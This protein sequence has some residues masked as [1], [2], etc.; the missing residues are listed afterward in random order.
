[1]LVNLCEFIKVDWTLWCMH[2]H[3]P[4]DFL[5][6]GIKRILLQEIVHIKI[7]KCDVLLS[8]EDRKPIFRTTIHASSGNGESKSGVKRKSE[9]VFASSS[10]RSRFDADWDWW[11]SSIRT[12]Y[13]FF[14]SFSLW[15]TSPYNLYHDVAS[16]G[17][18]LCANGYVWFILVCIY[19]Y[20]VISVLYLVI[21]KKIKLVVSRDMKDVFIIGFSCDASRLHT[22]SFLHFI[23]PHPNF[24]SFPQ[25]DVVI[26]D[27]LLG[28]TT[29]KQNSTHTT[30]V[31]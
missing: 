19:M 3:L 2:G 23:T 8:Q 25:I 22:Q 21:P 24:S 9:S 15:L 16:C 30:P 26:T 18:G 17:I 27:R 6:K 28:Q 11:F 7:E 12:H 29:W 20:F 14:P 13:L 5:H 10:K 1:M 4:M 31:P